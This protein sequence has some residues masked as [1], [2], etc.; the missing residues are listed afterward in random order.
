MNKLLIAL[1]VTGMTLG[2]AAPTFAQTAVP[3]PPPGAAA[4]NTFSGAGGLSAGAI[5][6]V[7]G[8]VIVVGIA[9]GGGSDGIT[10]TTTTST[11]P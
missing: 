9:V 7:I 4:P 3:T 8:A 1:T 6:G 2:L 10:T 11:R 5:A